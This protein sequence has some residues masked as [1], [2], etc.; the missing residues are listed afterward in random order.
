M[1]V[2]F[3]LL[4]Y[5][6]DQ[7]AACH[8][9]YQTL[10]SGLLPTPPHCPTLHTHPLNDQKLRI[11]SEIFRILSFCFRILYRNLVLLLS[12][13]Y[14]LRLCPRHLGVVRHEQSESRMHNRARS[15]LL[16]AIEHSS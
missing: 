3:S 13:P 1:S 15:K 5:C 6:A 2:L 11:L 10:L 9:S 14:T 7:I 16:L 12:F 8:S 4:Q